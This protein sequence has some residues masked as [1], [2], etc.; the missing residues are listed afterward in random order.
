[1]SRILLGNFLEFGCGLDLSNF[2]RIKDGRG[3]FRISIYEDGFGRSGSLR[4]ILF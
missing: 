2:F 3:L 1:M 4:F